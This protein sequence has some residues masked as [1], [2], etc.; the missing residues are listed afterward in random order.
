[1]AIDVS[2]ELR[3]GRKVEAPKGPTN[4]SPAFRGMRTRGI[5][6]SQLSTIDPGGVDHQ[7]RFQKIG[8]PLLGVHSVTVILIFRGLPPTATIG[9]R[10]TGLGAVPPSNAYEEIFK[11]SHFLENE[12]V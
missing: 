11:S 6:K 2:M 1:V 3:T 4:G 12:L 8:G 10:R 9:S 5:R 7:Q